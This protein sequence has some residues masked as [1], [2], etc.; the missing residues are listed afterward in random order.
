MSLR[1]SGML[2]CIGGVFAVLAGVVNAV[3]RPIVRDVRFLIPVGAYFIIV[4]AGTVFL[5][6]IAAVLLAVPLAALGIISI[7]ASIRSGSVGAIILNLLISGGLM[8][9]PAVI[10]NRNWVELR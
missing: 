10:I 5:R 8:C 4:G 2:T 9:A 1:M 3:H 6:R 7:V